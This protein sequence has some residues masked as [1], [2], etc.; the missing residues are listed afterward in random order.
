MVGRPPGIDVLDVLHVIPLLWSGAGRVLTRL[1]VL[2]SRS[3]R[4]GIVTATRSGVERDWPEYRRAL[5]RAGVGHARIDFFARDA[6]TF[7]TGARALAALID[8]ERPAI[9]HTHAGVPAAAAAVAR[10][11]SARPF[12]TVAQFY[13]WGLNRPDWMNE[14]DLWGFRRADRVL[15]SADAYRR[16]LVLG[17]VEPRRIIMVP[18]GVDATPERSCGTSPGRPLTLG[19]VGRIEPR[20][21]QLQLVRV[22]AGLRRWWPDVRLDLV[23][24]STDSAYDAAIREAITVSGM[25]GRVRLLG[26]VKNPADHVARWDLFVSL[27]RDEGQGMA[28]LEAMEMGIPVAASAVSGV[29]DFVSRGRHAFPLPVGLTTGQIT[30]RLRAILERRERMTDTGRRGRAFVRRHYG[31]TQTLERVLSAYRFKAQKGGRASG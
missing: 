17:G 25:D 14:M 15:C 8:R 10:T 3:L 23:G 18:W 4:V 22:A 6:E 13:S 27:S 19:F 1:C 21:Q 2:Q 11:L 30:R 16:L 9:V 7:W 12:R 24:P 20:K 28:I 5:L 29:E 26:K 31:W